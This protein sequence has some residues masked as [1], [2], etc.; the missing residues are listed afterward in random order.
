M[1]VVDRV[2]AIIPQIQ[3]ELP[4]GSRSTCWPTGRSR[5]AR[6][7]DDVEFTLA[8]AALLV[9]VAIYFF[10]RSFRATMIPAIALPISVIGT[11][12]ACISAATRSTTYHCWR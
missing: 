8:L 9:I 1:E 11:F 12:A 5:S 4:A 6:A 7:I 3:A 10:L 2:K